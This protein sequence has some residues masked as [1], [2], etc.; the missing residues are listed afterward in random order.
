MIDFTR[1]PKSHG[2]PYLSVTLPLKNYCVVWSLAGAIHGGMV[3]QTTAE[4]LNERARNLNELKA[5]APDSVKRAAQLGFAEADSLG[6]HDLAGEFAAIEADI[7]LAVGNLDAAWTRYSVALSRFQEGSHEDSLW[8]ASTAQIAMILANILLAQDKYIDAH[9]AYNELMQLAEALELPRAQAHATNNLGVLFLR[10]GDL[11]A[12]RG[13]FESAQQQFVELEEGYF[14]ALC[15]YNLA[16]INEKLGQTDAA[17]TGFSLTANRMAEMHEWG[18][19]VSCNTALARVHWKANNMPEAVHFKNIAIDALNS[20]LMKSSVPPPLY[21]TEAYYQAALIE[22]SR[23]DERE[24]E[25][26]ARTSLKEA[27][28]NRLQEQVVKSALLVSDLAAERGDADESLAMLQLHLDYLGQI[29]RE[30]S[31]KEIVQLQMQHE[32]EQQ[33]Q[34]AELRDLRNAAER[35][36]QQ[37]ILLTVLLVVALLSGTLAVLYLNLRNRNARARLRETQLELEAI[38]LNEHL[39]YKSKELTATMMYLLEKNQFI[40]SMAS[41]LAAAKNEFSQKNQVVIQRVINELLKNS[42]KKTWD[43][44][45]MH[46]KEVHVDFY[47]TLAERFPDLTVNEKRLCAFLKLHLTTK[48]IAAIT[49]QSVKS[50]NMARFRLRKKLNMESEEDLVGF[51]TSI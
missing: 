25:R 31:I 42:S 1:N 44:F 11:S 38:E 29:Q 40:T 50:I 34:E 46:F 16:T 7:A 23:G 4:E 2:T 45:E 21:R 9:D 33:L 43:E 10:L 22:Q 30:A 14:K 27:L 19:Y 12:A 36:R 20:E 15:A 5:A 18:D 32:F 17:I 35:D 37:A 28:A 47:K 39:N 24:A 8:D 49:H 26:L 41:E 48:E 3:A 13:Y 51:I 6:L